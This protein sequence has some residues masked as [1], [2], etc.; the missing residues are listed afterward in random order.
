M[1]KQDTPTSSSTGGK[2][3]LLTS[4][5][6][7]IA[8]LA[9]GSVSTYAL[10][11]NAS[12][13]DTLKGENVAHV[14]NDQTPVQATSQSG[15]G[16]NAPSGP[17]MQAETARPKNAPGMPGDMDVC[18][19]PGLEPGQGVATSYEEYF[20]FT[21]AY[22]AGHPNNEPGCTWGGRIHK[23]ALTRVI[24]SLPTENPYVRFKFGNSGPGTKTF[25]MFTGNLSPQGGSV[26]YRNSGN[27][28]AF[29]PSKCD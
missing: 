7:F 10:S 27:M 1:T 26:I 21:N 11:R 16:E 9:A 20:N 17:P 14:A 15:S 12:D 19:F 5:I 6:L 3:T 28:E 18:G 23:D 2:S 24:N 25:V 22:T 4:A 8:G 13:T 29:C